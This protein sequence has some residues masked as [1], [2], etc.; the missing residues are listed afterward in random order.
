MS[1]KYKKLARMFLL[2]EQSSK[3]LCCSNTI[4]VMNEMGLFPLLSATLL[5]RAHESIQ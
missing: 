1:R 4:Y 5:K 2:T 3:R